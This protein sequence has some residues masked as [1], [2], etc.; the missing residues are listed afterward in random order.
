MILSDW[1]PESFT[2]ALYFLLSEVGA[3]LC[4]GVGPT[5][6]VHGGVTRLS[7]CF[8]LPPVIVGFLKCTQIFEK[9]IPVFSVGCCFHY[10]T[11]YY[12]TFHLL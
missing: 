10:F 6:F 7:I 11:L 2:P 4:W 1:C 5:A 8:E 12:C 3:V 9:I